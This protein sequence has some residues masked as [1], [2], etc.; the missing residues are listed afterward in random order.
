MTHAEAWVAWVSLAALGCTGAK[1]VSHE[2]FVSPANAASAPAPDPGPEGKSFVAGVET[3]G[4]FDKTSITAPAFAWS[5]SSLSARFSGHSVSV[6]LDDAT[7][8]NRFAVIVDGKVQGAKLSVAR[9]SHPYTLASG[10]APGSHEVTLYRLTEANQGETNFLGFRFGKG[11]ALLPRAPHVS[12]RLEIIGDS[13]STGYGNE[14]ADKNCKFS[15]ETE[16]HFLTYEAIAARKLDADLVTI[17]W[18]G[19]GV[20]SNRGSTVDT[21]VMPVLW[22]RTLPE[23]ADSRWDFSGYQPDAVV[24]NL[25]SNDFAPEVRDTSPFGGAYLAFVREVRSHY[26]SA[27]ILC[28]VGPVLSDTWPEGRKA[29]TQARQAIKSAVD[30]LRQGGD[31]KVSFL[32]FPQQTEVNGYGCDWHPSLKTHEIMAGLLEKELRATM[33]W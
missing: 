17:A 19:K 2:A 16:N 3:V 4:R 26:P 6:D 15:P 30:T 28:T 29:L 25:G 12:R 7:G 8:N 32:E 31:A 22:K 23:R 10:L 13:I 33:S 5:G 20:F 24:I 18:S 14:G 9:G 27:A 11:G 21:V 1:A